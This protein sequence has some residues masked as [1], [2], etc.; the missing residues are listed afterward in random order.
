M[1]VSFKEFNLAPLQQAVEALGFTA[2]TPVQEKVFP[3]AM[4][5]GDL[6]VSSQTGSGKTASFLLPLIATN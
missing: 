5:G 4:S 2:A 6:M 1:S 3:V